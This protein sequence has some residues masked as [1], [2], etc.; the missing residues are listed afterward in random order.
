MQKMH[1]A[2]FSLPSFLTWSPAGRTLIFFLAAS[3][4]WSL[5]AEFYHLCS[6]RTFTLY[7]EILATALLVLNEEKGSPLIIVDG[8]MIRR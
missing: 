6:M 1:P 2:H 4:I 5:L 3:S 7:V 8:A